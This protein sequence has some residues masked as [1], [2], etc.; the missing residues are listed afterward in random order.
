MRARIYQPA[1]TAM[2]SGQAKTKDWVLDFAPASSREVDPL[3]GWTSSDDT[4]SQ[5]RLRFPTKEAALDYAK[6]N[7]I[8]A[9]VQDPKSRAHN[10]RAGGYGENFATNRRQVWTH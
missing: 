3:M 5:V 10:V 6:A 4:Q 9:A 2:Q 1:R 7:G 8:D